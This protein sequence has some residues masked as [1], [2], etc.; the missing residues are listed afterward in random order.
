MIRVPTQEEINSVQER[1]S[2]TIILPQVTTG[3]KLSD[4]LEQDSYSYAICHLFIGGQH[5]KEL[6]D[7]YLL[8]QEML[9]NLSSSRSQSSSRYPAP[10]ALFFI[11][12]V[13]RNA[14]VL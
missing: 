6:L 8:C 11:P 2:G 1:T 4:L 13:V 9:L 5:Q 10:K 14:D 3:M 12:S 7:K